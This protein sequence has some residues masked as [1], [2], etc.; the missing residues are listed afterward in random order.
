MAWGVR[1]SVTLDT[2][3]EAADAE[4]S[5]RGSSDFPWRSSVRCLLVYRTLELSQLVMF[6]LER[7]NITFYFYIWFVSQKFRRSSRWLFQQH[8]SISYFCAVGET[9]TPMSCDICSWSIRVYQF[10][11]HGLTKKSI[12]YRYTAIKHYIQ[13]PCHYSWLFSKDMIET[14]TESESAD[15]ADSYQSFLSFRLE[16]RKRDDENKSH[17]KKNRKHYRKHCRT[18]KQ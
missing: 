2:K 16:G 9:W 1:V 10:H 13:I 5:K 17:P 3:T 18:K 6:C 11:H 12:S 7:Q 14:T 15:V 8:K 4:Y